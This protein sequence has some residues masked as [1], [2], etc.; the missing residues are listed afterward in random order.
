MVAALNP[1]ESILTKGQVEEQPQ[2]SSP[3][4]SYITIWDIKYFNK[5]VANILYTNFLCL[6]TDDT[7]TW[8]NHIGQLI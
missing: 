7:L 8:D 6:V 2:P 4:S 3:G 1:I 5:I